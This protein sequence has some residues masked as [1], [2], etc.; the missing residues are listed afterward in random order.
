MHPI[1]LS[2]WED[3][4]WRGRHGMR[5]TWWPSWS[6]PWSGTQLSE[7]EHE[8]DDERRD[9]WGAS[10]GHYGHLRE[11]GVSRFAGPIEDERGT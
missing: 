5:T 2:G 6:E 11:L 4:R 7:G 3:R 8:D 1:L 10:E 9:I